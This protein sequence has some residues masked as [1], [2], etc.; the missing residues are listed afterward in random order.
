[1]ETALRRI[2]DMLEAFIDA[3]A[4]W[5]ATGA[6]RPEAWP[7]ITW[8]LVAAFLVLSWLLAWRRRGPRGLDVRPPPQ[9]L[10]TSGEVV[11]DGTDEPERRPS[12]RRRRRPAPQADADAGAYTMTVSNLSRYPVQLLEVALRDG[13][14]GAPRVATVD[15]VVPA[16]GSVSVSGRIALGLRGDGWLDLYCYAAAPR[17]KVHRHRVELV[18]EPWAARFK[19]APLEQV[20]APARRLA[21]DEPDA[22]F[23]EDD[24]PEAVEPMAVAV[25]VDVPARPA[26]RRDAPPRSA[27]HPASID[28]GATWTT[29]AAAA[30]LEP[31][32]APEPPAPVTPEPAAA[33]AAASPRPEGTHPTAPSTARPAS[34][35]VEARGVPRIGTPPVGVAVTGRGGGSA[36]TAD[37][38]PIGRPTAARPEREPERDPAREAVRQPVR[39]VVPAAVPEPERDRERAR[40]VVRRTPVPA[41]SAPPPS[42]LSAADEDESPRQSSARR[43]P[44]LE[45]P[46]EF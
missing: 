9:L 16:M 41:T 8:V 4:A 31:A 33:A 39:A 26:E 44:R 22:R 15:A 6:W 2:A 5:F 46:D 43:R 13:R 18:W 27:A 7:G 40:A 36:R 29:A 19:A 42:P 1:M 20:S 34:A 14:R 17:V 30:V 37:G 32:A 3:F 21:S 24:V 23:L 25:A 10:V 12:G 38:L 45:F 35:A 28:D 11:P